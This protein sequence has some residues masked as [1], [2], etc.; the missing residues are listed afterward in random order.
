MLHCT[1]V[2]LA[3]PDDSFFLNDLA[4]V[5]HTAGKASSNVRK[6]LYACLDRYLARQWRGVLYA[7]ILG[8]MDS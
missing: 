6:V 3:V 1:H 4:T 8:D 2:K 7:D 5:S